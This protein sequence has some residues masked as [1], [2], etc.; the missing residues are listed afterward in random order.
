MKVF[1]SFKMFLQNPGGIVFLN[2]SAD[3]YM[4]M[5]YWGSDQLTKFSST[6][7]SV[8]SHSSADGTAQL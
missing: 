8:K 3:A 7:G 2:M 5:M 6:P 4:S 1:S